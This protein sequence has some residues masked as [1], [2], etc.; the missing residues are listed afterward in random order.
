MS[1]DQILFRLRRFL[2]ALSAL[3]FGGTVIELWLAEHM[4][5][6]VQLIPFGLCGLGIVAV[7][8][9]LLRPQRQTLLGLRGCMGLAVLGSLYGMYEHISS[10]IAFQLEIQPNAKFRDIFSE[11]LGGASPLLAP[12]ILVLAAI[13]AIAATYYHPALE[14]SSEKRRGRILLK[15]NLN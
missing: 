11:A 7:I 14:R 13:L 12:G 4:E 2:L 15:E 10:N 3:L 9:V 8:A 1:P 5:S 6:L